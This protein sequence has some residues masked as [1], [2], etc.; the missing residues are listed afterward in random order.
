M[1]T[2]NPCCHDCTDFDEPEV[3]D[4][5]C[6]TPMPVRRTCEAPVL[7]TKE[8]EEDE[9]VVEYDPD[10]ERFTVVTILYDQECSPIT[11]ENDSPITTV[12][13]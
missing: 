11:D 13:G 10:T 3:A 4:H 5:G 9:P 8:C 1:S 6:C 2:R 7:P 12:I